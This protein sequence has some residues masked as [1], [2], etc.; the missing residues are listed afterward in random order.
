MCSGD[1]NPPR[2]MSESRPRARKEH[3]CCEC[4]RLIPPGPKGAT[5]SK[6]WMGTDDEGEI[7]L[8][9][10]ATQQWLEGHSP[11]ADIDPA[12]GTRECRICRRG[13]FSAYR[14]RKADREERP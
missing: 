7:H 6:P 2:V 3:R 5:M 12:G 11:G 14:K 1:D 8:D 13:W 10:L 9:N 4:G